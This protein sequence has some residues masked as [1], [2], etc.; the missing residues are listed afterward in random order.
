MVQL[1]PDFLG[2]LGSLFMV[3]PYLRHQ[4]LRRLLDLV[5]HTRPQDPDARRA[6]AQSAADLVAYLRV[7]DRRDY[8]LTAVG[9]GLLCLSFLTKLILVWISEA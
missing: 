9:V 2:F 6:A 4:P 8:R 7:W 1:L 3:I 5:Q